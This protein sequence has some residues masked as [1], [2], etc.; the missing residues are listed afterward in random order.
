[1]LCT[2]V[3]AAVLLIVFDERPTGFPGPG[4]R[5]PEAAVGAPHSSPPSAA[6]VRFESQGEALLSAGFTDSLSDW[7]PSA[8]QATWMA[9]EEGGGI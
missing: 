8:G 6:E 4:A 1:M 5:P 9:E 3:I 2:I 7:E